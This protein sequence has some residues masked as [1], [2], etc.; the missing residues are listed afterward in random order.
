[1]AAIDI[2]PILKFMLDKGGSDLFFSTGASIHIEIEGDTLPINA[3]I[4]T[5]GTVSYTHLDVYK[6]QA[7]A[8]PKH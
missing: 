5:P 7:R 2:S 3:Q 8:L 4:M 6:R 1:M